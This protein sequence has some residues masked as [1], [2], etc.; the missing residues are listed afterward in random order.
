MD[1][2]IECGCEVLEKQ[3]LE[4]KHSGCNKTWI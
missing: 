3:V 2:C 4:P 1:R